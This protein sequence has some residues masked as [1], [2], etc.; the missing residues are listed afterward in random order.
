M[1]G[2]HHGRDADDPKDVQDVGSDDV[3]GSDLTLPLSRCS[4]TGANLG[5]RGPD[6]ND[7]QPNDNFRYLKIFSNMKTGP[8]DQPARDNHTRETKGKPYELS[9][10]TWARLREGR[11]QS[12]LVGGA[13]QGRGS[14]D[15]SLGGDKQISD[16]SCQDTHED[17]SL[18]TG[19]NPVDRHDVSQSIDRK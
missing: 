4:N 3:P 7:S 17:Q 13:C 5:E 11:V 1:H 6:G 8:N 15:S 2:V 19:K 16:V 10:E 12:M 14:I 9:P 18:R